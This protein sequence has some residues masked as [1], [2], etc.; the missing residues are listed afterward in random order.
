MI[1]GVVIETGRR[2]E[3]GQ[4]SRDDE[5]EPAMPLD[6]ENGE[7]DGA[8]EV[9]IRAKSARLIEMDRQVAEHGRDPGRQSPGPA[10]AARESGVVGSPGQRLPPRAVAQT[11]IDIAEDAARLGGGDRE[12]AERREHATCRGGA[13]IDLKSGSELGGQLGL[14]GRDEANRIDSGNRAV[15][16]GQVVARDDFKGGGEEG[17]FAQGDRRVDDV[18]GTGQMLKQQDESGGIVDDDIPA[19]GDRARESRQGIRSRAQ[20]GQVDNDVR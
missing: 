3:V 6:A 11:A 5:A 13:G 10:Q 19:S 12:P 18:V 16:E 14:P 15:D 1:E 20:A 9:R 17:V 4:G 8:N 7:L 2:Q